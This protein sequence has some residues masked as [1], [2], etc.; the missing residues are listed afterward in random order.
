VPITRTMTFARS[1]RCRLRDLMRSE[2]GI[3][4]PVA[5]FTTVAAMALGGVAILSSID[6]QHGVTRDNGSKSAIAAADAG[7]NVALHRLNSYALELNKEKP[8]LA[9]NASGKLEPSAAPKGGKPGWCASIENEEVGGATFSYW[10]S[11]VGSAKEAGCALD[12]CIVSTGSANNVSRRVELSLKESAWGALISNPKLTQ[13]LKETTEGKE[14]TEHEIKVLEEQLKK[15]QEE[16]SHGGFVPGLAGKNE[17]TI[18]GNGNIRVGVGT[19]GNLVTSG[20]ASICGDILVGVGKSWKKSGNATQCSGHTVTQG[21]LTL[22]EVSS[23]MP[24]NIATS[25]SDYRLVKCTKTTEPKS[26]TGCQSD[27]YSGG[28]WTTTSPWNPSTRAI[29]ASGN[30]TL[31]IGGGDYWICSITLSGNSQLI[32]AAGAHARFF[33]DTP[34]HCGTSNQ[35]SMSGNNVITASGYQPSKSQF[36]MP[37][38]YLLG[39]PTTASQL[40]LSGNSSTTDEFVIYGPNTDISISGNAT[41][42]GIVAG[43]TISMSG[44]GTIEQDAGY[45]APPEITP[46]GNGA[47]AKA[48]EELLSQKKVS[49]TSLEALIKQYEGELNGEPESE[50][51]HTQDYVECTGTV[52]TGQPNSA[53]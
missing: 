10:V 18:S 36:D 7:A 17:I 27:T 22:P 42:K 37:G 19:N 16:A 48:I 15:A 32:M 11:A 4:L 46:G 33:F 41:F 39:S 26:P 21:T 45:T 14:L 9:K 29:S 44:N 1:I 8:C 28:T 35:I 34:E 23:F 2:Q 6:V 40:S 5:L 20:N 12:I 38:F 24:S 53:C 3:A 30:T 52:A 49:K 51:F 50:A 47:A 25:N 43:K 13:E 31:T